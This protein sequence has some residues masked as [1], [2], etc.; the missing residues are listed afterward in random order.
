MIP[1]ITPKSRPEQPP[2]IGGNCEYQ[3]NTGSAW[4]CLTS[5]EYSQYIV[6]Y[7]EAQSVMLLLAFFVVLIIG[8]AAF[9]FAKISKSPNTPS[10]PTLDQ[11]L[12]RIWQPTLAL[13]IP[14]TT[15]IEEVPKIR[16]LLT[17]KI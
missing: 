9:I 4:K 10:S 1:L 7:Q 2:S 11:C 13:T 17:K 3:V 14:G 5:Q 8:L 12:L 15:T 6:R 16:G